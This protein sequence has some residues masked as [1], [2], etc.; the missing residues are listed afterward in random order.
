M[1]K[2]TQNGL[3]LDVR[4][5]TTKCLEENI[6]VKLLDNLTPKAKVN[7]WDDIKLKAF[8]TAKETI[9]KIKR[10]PIKWEKIFADHLC[11]RG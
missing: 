11:D 10:Q 2:L 3:D 4:P 5:E 9:N 1:Q 8:Y 6:S 7:K